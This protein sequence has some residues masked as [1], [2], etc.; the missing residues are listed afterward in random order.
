MNA[1]T[2]TAQAVREMPNFRTNKDQVV[3]FFGHGE[4][5]VKYIGKCPVSG[6]RMYDMP[7]AAAP[8][9]DYTTLEAAEYDMSGPDFVYSW[10]ASNDAKL[11]AK[12]LE[13]AKKTWFP[14]PA[15]VGPVKQVIVQGVTWF[16]K[17]NGNHYF[18]ATVYA[19]GQ[20]VLELPSQYGSPDSIKNEALN[21]LDK[22]GF[23]EIVRHKNFHHEYSSDWAARTGAAFEVKHY[24]ASYDEYKQRG[25]YA[26]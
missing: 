20:R 1:P 4:Y 19:N 16:D 9:H 2:T 24:A 14:L 23:I 8:D 22:A 11:A 3:N 6:I 5:I 13:L 25:R 21:E 15:T 26:N 12:A 17:V 7:G 10:L 18:R